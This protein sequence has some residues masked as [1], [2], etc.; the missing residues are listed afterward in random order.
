MAG[1]L[2][3]R[4]EARALRRWSELLEGASDAQRRARRSAARWARRGVAAAWNTL[5]AHFERTCLLQAV[6]AQ[7]ASRGVAAALRGW[8]EAA[9]LGGSA[10][11]PVRALQRA[12]VASGRV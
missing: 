2:T 4:A 5:L 6:A 12:P 8:S 1:S 11:L 10:P 3:R 9:A 7:W